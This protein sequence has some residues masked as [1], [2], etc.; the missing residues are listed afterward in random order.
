MN[1]WWRGERNTTTTGGIS[2]PESCISFSFFTLISPQKV[3][4]K[5]RK[6]TEKIHSFSL[7]LS[8]FHLFHHTPRNL[9]FLGFL[10][11]CVWGGVKKV[12]EMAWRQFELARLPKLPLVARWWRSNKNAVGGVRQ[13]MSETQSP[14]NQWPP[15]ALARVRNGVS[16]KSVSGHVSIARTRLRGY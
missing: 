10:R 5:N 7:S 8:F 13:K 6:N 2:T 3:N 15:K 9:L 4:E 12:K 16:G 11:V 1:Y 14:P